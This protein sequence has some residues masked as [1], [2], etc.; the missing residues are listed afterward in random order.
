[1]QAKQ[2]KHVAIDERSNNSNVEKKKKKCVHQQ[3][4]EE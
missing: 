3:K 4:D 1:M 2:F